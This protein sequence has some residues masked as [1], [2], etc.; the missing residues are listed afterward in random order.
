L[1]VRGDIGVVQ[2]V[3]GHLVLGLAE[4]LAVTDALRVLDLLEMLFCLVE[5]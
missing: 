4:H 2:V 3:P 5:P 1:P